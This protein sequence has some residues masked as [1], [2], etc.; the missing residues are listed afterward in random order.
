M[1]GLL[2]FPEF[3][4]DSLA[5]IAGLQSLV[6]VTS[7]FA[8]MAGNAPCLTRERHCGHGGA[9]DYRCLIMDVGK[10]TKEKRKVGPGPDVLTAEDDQHS[11]QHRGWGLLPGAPVVEGQL[12]DTQRGQGQSRS[13]CRGVWLVETP[14][15]AF[16]A[17][18]AHPRHQL[19]ALPSG[20]K[21]FC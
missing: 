9:T 21:L 2:F 5:H 14:V 12:Q 7:L 6:A 11:T 15:K 3:P 19:G 18:L 13:G 10:P 17:C 8:D 4:Q 20:R 16:S 1:A